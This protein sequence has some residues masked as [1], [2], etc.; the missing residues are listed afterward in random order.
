MGSREHTK[1]LKTFFQSIIFLNIFFKVGNKKKGNILT[2]VSR[3][4]FFQSLFF[5]YGVQSRKINFR[6]KFF[7]ISIPKNYFSEVVL[8]LKLKK[9]TE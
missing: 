4:F 5:Q 8:D 7:G 3:D 2:L 1:V 9:R 6:K